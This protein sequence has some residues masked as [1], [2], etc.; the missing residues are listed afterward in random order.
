MVEALGFIGKLAA[1]SS[2]LLF[3][4]LPT[5]SMDISQIQVSSIQKQTAADFLFHLLDASHGHLHVRVS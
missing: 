3:V 2:Q 5:I 4:L 1:L